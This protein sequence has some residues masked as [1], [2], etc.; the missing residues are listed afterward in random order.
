MEFLRAL[1]AMFL[2]MLFVAIIVAKADMLTL[3]N[4]AQILSLAIVAAG[5]L[6]HSEK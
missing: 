6:A 3:S 2:F 4:D 5:A 1:I